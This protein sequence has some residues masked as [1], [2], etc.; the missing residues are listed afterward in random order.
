MPAKWLFLSSVNPLLFHQ[1]TEC[2]CVTDCAILVQVSK[3]RARKRQEREIENVCVC[4]TEGERKREVTGGW[5]A[6]WQRGKAERVMEMQSDRN[7]SLVHLACPGVRRRVSK[8]EDMVTHIH[9]RVRTQQIKACKT[10]FTALL[11]NKVLSHTLSS[12]VCYPATL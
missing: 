4:V 12:K 7:A 2:E 11:V 6:D 1:D 9:T 8:P 5:K 10:S 3:K